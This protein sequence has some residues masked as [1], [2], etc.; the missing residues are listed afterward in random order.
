[1]CSNQLCSD[2][3]QTGFVK[4][5]QFWG[6]DFRFCIKYTVWNITLCFD[7]LIIVII[8]GDKESKALMCFH[9]P[10]KDVR[11]QCD[12]DQVGLI[13]ILLTRMSSGQKIE[14][15]TLSCILC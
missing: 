9:N 3:I 12:A 7:H 6:S 2:Y 10:V 11:L 15:T 8:C 5:C 4:S 14:Q 13:L 1:M